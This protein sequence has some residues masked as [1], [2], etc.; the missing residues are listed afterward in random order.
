MPENYDGEGYYGGTQEP[1][2]YRQYYESSGHLK[3]S[4]RNSPCSDAYYYY[5]D[6]TNSAR[7]FMVSNIGL[8]AKRGS[9]NTLHVISTQLDSAAPL[10][11]ARITAFNYQ[12]Q[13]IGSGH[14][15]QHGMVDITKSEEHTSEL[16][17]RPHLVCRL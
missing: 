11:N 2:W 15:D 4:E 6:T 3:Y 1:S 9:D 17:S 5:G 12:Q 16:Q 8:M 10:A 7:T 14:T 13:T